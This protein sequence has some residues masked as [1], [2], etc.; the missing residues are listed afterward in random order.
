MADELFGKLKIDDGFFRGLGFNDE[1]V[2]SN[3]EL[4]IE[5]Y[6]GAHDRDGHSDASANFERALGVFSVSY[7]RIAQ[8]VLRNRETSLTPEQKLFL[9]FGFLDP[10]IVQNRKVV[11]ELI[12]EV[13]I[14]SN[15]DKYEIY[16]L[17]EWMEKIARGSISLTSDVAQIKK[18]T[19]TKEEEDKL[20]EKRRK[21]E[22]EVKG[23]EAEETSHYAEFEKISEQFSPDADQGE[24]TGLLAGMRKKIAEIERT[25]R[26]ENTRLAEIETLK[27]REGC[28]GE[29]SDTAGSVLAD[30]QNT[31]YARIREE[32]DILITVMRSCAARGRLVKNTPVLVDKWMPLDTRLSI[33]TRGFVEKRLAELEEIDCQIFGGK[34][35]RTVPKILIL[36][37]V[38]TGMAW[39]DR[40]MTPLFPPPNVPPEISMVRTLASYRWFIATT[41]FHWKHLT[42]EL[43]GMYQLIYP[44]LTYTS[45]E[46]SFVDDYT[47]W[48]TKESQGFQ[49][50]NAAVRNLFWK[51]IPFSISHK[52]KLVKRATIYRKLYAE[53]LARAHKK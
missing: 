51:K 33:N 7:V 24:K 5:F 46:K 20:R 47:D 18:K 45:L 13:E 27:A 9:N 3:M 53:E 36:P 41:S 40:I 14:K 25:V 15:P 35:A 44:E 10:R 49:V 23:F 21:L 17:N 19:K 34:G 43:G 38:G 26:E 8:E 4:G 11:D 37:G 2:L 28:A 39:K 48:I 42:D 1:K 52:E 30:R 29:T 22:E 12:R 31:K 6:L 16:Y 32:F 50:L